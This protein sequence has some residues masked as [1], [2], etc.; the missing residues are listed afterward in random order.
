MPRPIPDFPSEDAERAFWAEHDSA[1][2]IDWR[3][4]QPVNYPNLKP[5]TRTILVPK[6]G[7]AVEDRSD[8]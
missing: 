2:Y 1:E 4:A 3:A 8:R 6:R 7:H 5:T